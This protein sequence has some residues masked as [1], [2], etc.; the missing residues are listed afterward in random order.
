MAAQVKLAVDRRRAAQNPAAGLFQTAAAEMRLGL[1][2]VAPVESRRIVGV[3]HCGGDAQEKAVVGRS[4]L[5]EQDADAIRFGEPRGDDCAGASR[6]YDD[7]V[8]A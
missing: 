2:L 8:M 5:K 6:A 1:R 3:A 7:I 4:C